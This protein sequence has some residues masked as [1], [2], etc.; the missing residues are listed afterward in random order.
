MIIRI[1]TTDQDVT[2]G[3]EWLAK[4]DARFAQALREAGPLP[5]RR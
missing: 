1:I 5:L 4:L 2:E 3:A